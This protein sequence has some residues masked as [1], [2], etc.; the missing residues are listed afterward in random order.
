VWKGKE[1][2]GRVWYRFDHLLV[3]LKCPLRLLRVYTHYLQD[4]LEAKDEG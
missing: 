3:I 2:G 4:I 1:E